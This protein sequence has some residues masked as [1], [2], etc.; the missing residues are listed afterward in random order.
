MKAKPTETEQQLNA[1]KRLLTR[2]KF[3]NYSART[4]IA[5]ESV[6]TTIS[7]FYHD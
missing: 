6:F 3:D 7:E 2:P 1:E 4:D 5:P